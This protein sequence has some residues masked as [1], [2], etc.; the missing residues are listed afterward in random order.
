MNWPR[1]LKWQLNKLNSKLAVIG[2]KAN[3]QV[4]AIQVGQAADS[5]DQV[6][7]EEGPELVASINGRSARLLNEISLQI[8]W[9]KPGRIG[10]VNE[11]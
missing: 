11:P 7:S 4:L 5:R 3:I 2:Q 9:H 6:L 10:L 8:V 1:Q